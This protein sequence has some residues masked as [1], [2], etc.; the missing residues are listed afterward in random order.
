MQISIVKLKVLVKMTGVMDCI[1]EILQHIIESRWENPFR[2]IF[3]MTK[4]TYYQTPTTL[5]QRTTFRDIKLNAFDSDPNSYFSSYM[6][7][8]LLNEFI[9]NAVQPR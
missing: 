2:W 8:R 5:G 6:H 9:V 3:V 4:F 1:D 7:M